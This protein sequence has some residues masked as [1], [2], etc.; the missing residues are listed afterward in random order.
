MPEGDA[1]WRTAR[2]LDR[3]LRGDE[4]VGVD[5]R[6]GRLPEVELRGRRTIEVV[7][8][9]KHILHRIDSG[10]TLH[11]HLRMD[12]SWRVV[13]TPRVSPRFAAHA[14]IRALVATAEKACAGR[15]LGMLNLVRTR[16]EHRLVG[17]LG[18]DILGADWDEDEALRRLRAN[19]GRPIGAALLDQRNLAGLGTIWTTEPLFE[20]GVDPWLPVDRL[21]EGVI[22]DV[23]QIAHR[24]LHDAI[25]EGRHVPQAYERKGWPCPR[26]GAKLR[27]GMIG[28]APQARQL[29][30]CPS[31]QRNPSHG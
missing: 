4:L 6:M 11:S 26:C 17:H 2:R 25:G 27:I 9:G 14:D 10:W 30:Y 15:K 13:P 7:P 31:C 5:L 8:R 21:D 29:T 28:D 3:A 12:G 22:R 19:G 23:L 20:R 18:P 1:V 24:M 16:D